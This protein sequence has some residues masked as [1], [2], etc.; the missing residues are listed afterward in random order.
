MV[1]RHAFDNVLIEP[2]TVVL[3]EELKERRFHTVHS[4][5]AASGAASRSQADPAETAGRWR[6][7]GVS[8]RGR[9]AFFY[10]RPASLKPRVA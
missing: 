4:A 3:G 7:R 9:G 2:G 10:V 5:A 8:L 1:R 6:G